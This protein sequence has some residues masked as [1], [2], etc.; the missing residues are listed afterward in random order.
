MQPKIQF[1]TN[2]LRIRE[3]INK[4]GEAK[5]RTFLQKHLAKPESF[6]QFCSLFPQYTTNAMPDFH[7]EMVS[8]VI[9]GMLIDKSA[10]TRFCFG[11]PRG[12]AK[13]S[14]FNVLFNAWCSVNGFFHFVIPISDTHDQAKL[15]LGALKSALEESEII[16]WIYPDLKGSNWGEERIVVNSLQG[17]VLILARGA[18]MKIRGLRFKQYRPQLAIIDDLENS[19][20]VYS[21]DRRKKLKSWFDNDLEPAFDRYNKNIVFIGTVL[22]YHS[23]LKQVLD[24]QGKYTSWNTRIYKALTDDGISLWEDRFSAEYLRGMRDDPQ[25][26]D[27]V[28][29]IVFAQEFQNEPQDDKDRIIKLEWIKDYEFKMEYLAWP[30]E[31]ETDKKKRYIKENFT[32][33]FAGFD[34]AI[35]EKESADNCSLYVAGLEKDTAK[36]KMLDLIVKKEGDINKQRDF[37]CDKVVEWGV[38]VLGIESVAYQRGL[39]NIVKAELNRR[40]V[41]I[42]IM[43]I[44]TDKD[45]IR[46]ARIH[47]SGFEGGFILLRA[48]HENYSIIKSEIEEFPRGANDDAFDSLMLSREARQTGGGARAF[49]NKP[50]IFAR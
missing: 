19:E 28:G 38:D 15:H 31:D 5:T 46:R 36:E 13:S 9:Y 50:R 42:K 22:H 29:S 33:R 14:L 40:G 48:D 25:N 32:M 18:G 21:A 20:L 24:K 4:F 11:A 1:N 30:G 17:E 26:P 47:S 39:Y 6:L 16:N 8:E 2:P 37:I 10:G 27:Y 43:P 35:S 7:E 23:L 3:L 12:F 34:P 44:Q 49:S 45:K 41:Y